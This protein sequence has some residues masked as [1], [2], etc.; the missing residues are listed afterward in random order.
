MRAT[1]I[2]DREQGAVGPQRPRVE[3][4]RPGK[5]VAI[6]NTVLGSG[7]I[8]SALTAIPKIRACVLAEN[9]LVHEVLCRS[10]AKH[11][12]ITAV[13]VP[14]DGVFTAAGI[15]KKPIDGLVLVSSERVQADLEQ[16]SAIRKQA[17]G[18]KILLMGSVKEDA[19]FF[20]VCSRRH[21]W[22]FVAG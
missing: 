20:A 1:E 2:G 17:P 8:S 21:Q 5:S 13:G 22:I 7:L 15:P 18:L 9:H 14:A 16:I 6:L 11:E 12:K 3:S 19:E 10:L 4:A